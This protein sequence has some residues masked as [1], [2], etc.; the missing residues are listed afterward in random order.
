MTRHLFVDL[1]GQV[2]YGANWGLMCVAFHPQFKTNRRYF[3]KHQIEEDGVV[4]TAIVERRA[5]EDLLHDSGEP[6]RRLIAVEC[7]AYNH[8]G[9]C[10]GFGLDGMLY[11]AFG[12]GGFQH[13]PM[14]TARIRTPHWP[15]CFASMSIIAMKVA[16]MRFPRTIRSR[17][18]TK[19][20][21]PTCRKFGRAGCA[22]RGDSVSIRKRANSGSATSAKTNGEE[23]PS[24][25]PAK[26]WLECHGRV[27]AA[28]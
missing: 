23:C 26:S 18:N 5:S 8:N 6:S 19:A 14:A 16:S 7:P 13:D 24:S 10:I 11:I 28:F 15:K 9:G 4:K 27:R 17:M 22:S 1:T 21:R 2:K 12:D 20:I 25:T 3:L